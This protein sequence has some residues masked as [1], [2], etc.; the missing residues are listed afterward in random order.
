MSASLSRSVKVGT[1]GDQTGQADRREVK[2]PADLKGPETITLEDVI[3][4]IESRVKHRLDESNSPVFREPAKRIGASPEVD[5]LRRDWLEFL[6]KA[7]KIARDVVAA[8][9]LAEIGKLE[10]EREPVRPEATGTVPD[11][12]REQTR[13]S[14]RDCS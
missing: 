4:W 9:K 13:R 3:E 6:K 11:H 10:Q 8:D 12:R 5:H 14:A 7:L 1:A 2:L